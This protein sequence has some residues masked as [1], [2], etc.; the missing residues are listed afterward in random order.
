MGGYAPGRPGE[1]ESMLRSDVER[2]LIQGGNAL[3]VEDHKTFSQYG[4]LGRYIPPG[5]I[6]AMD[7]VLQI[8]PAESI[9]FLSP[10]GAAGKRVTASN[11]LA[12]YGDIYTPGF[13]RPGPTLQ[14]KFFCT[15]A[16]DESNQGKAFKV[17]AELDGHT[18]P[19]AKSNYVCVKPKVS[20][21]DCRGDYW[22][23]SRERARR[24]RGER[25]RESV[26][27]TVR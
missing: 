23:K 4:A 9:L 14:R 11:L 5:N 26:G 19:T 2:L 18:V 17:L 6:E 1:W 25:E 16:F 13:Q 27:E 8:H 12:R 3:I 15:A 22:L 20:G 10:T 7:R 21:E 24:I